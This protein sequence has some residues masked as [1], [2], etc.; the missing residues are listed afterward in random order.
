MQVGQAR[1]LIVHIGAPKT[2]SSSVQMFLAGH[3]DLLREHDITFPIMY[4]AEVRYFANGYGFLAPQDRERLAGIINSAPTGSVLFS[5]EMLFHTGALDSI[6]DPAWVSHKIKIILYLRNAPEYLA[7]L[8]GEMNKFENRTWPGPLPDYLVSGAYRARLEDFLRFAKQHPEIDFVVRPYNGNSV[9]AFLSLLGIAADTGRQDADENLSEPRRFADMMQEL[10]R[11]D[12][13]QRWPIDTGKTAA[14]LRR[15]SLQLRSG[16][17]RKIVETMDDATIQKIADEHRPLL[18][19]C[20]SR[21]G[22]SEAGF[23]ELP[24]CFGRPRERYQPLDG[25]DLEHIRRWVTAM[26]TFIDET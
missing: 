17:T 2:G 9:E 25:D 7:S 13:L 3:P 6:I 22:T 20:F 16:D 14:T 19:E 21:Y 15:L 1:T 10:F 12:L 26:R 24:S 4:P 5:E 11:H 18:E 8:W 23:S